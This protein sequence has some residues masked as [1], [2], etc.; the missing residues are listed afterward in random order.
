[1]QVDLCLSLG[2]LEHYVSVTFL[3]ITFFSY[4]FQYVEHQRPQ[5][6][7]CILYDKLLRK[8]VFSQSSTVSTLSVSY[9]INYCGKNVFSQSS[10]TVSSTTIYCFDIRHA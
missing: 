3:S 5:Y 10:Y 1:M 8:N 9:T 7:I 2:K 4:N 6:I